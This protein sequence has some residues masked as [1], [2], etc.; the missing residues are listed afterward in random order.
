MGLPFFN[1]LIS[2]NLKL[3]HH[4]SRDVLAA[5][6]LKLFLLFVKIVTYQCIMF[7]ELRL[8][9]TVDANFWVTH[10]EG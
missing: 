8:K 7:I 9:V 6:L 3:Y 5:R 10:S 2:I 1:V 4:G